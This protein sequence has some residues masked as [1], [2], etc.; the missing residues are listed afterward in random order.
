VLNSNYKHAYEISV[1]KFRS[2]F[3]Q[4][5]GLVSV[6][7]VNVSCSKLWFN[8]RRSSKLKISYYM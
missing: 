7:K 8:C 2:R 3:L 1:L 4:N 5:L 6:S